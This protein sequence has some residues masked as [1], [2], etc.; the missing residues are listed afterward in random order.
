M[1]RVN[2]Q[3]H[4]GLAALAFLAATAAGCDQE[5]AVKAGRAAEPAVSRVEVVTP[6]RVTMRRT[7]EQ[8]GQ[9][10]AFEV[11]PLYA[12]VSGYVEKWNVDI[13]TKVTKGQVLAVLSVPEL[14][15]EA[16]QKE[17]MIEAAGAVLFQAKASEDVAQANLFRRTRPS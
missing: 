15:A 10:D 13:G 5:S 7:T 11:T 12:K 14:D 2:V 4:V 17:A 9:I 8:P 3:K 1:N 6:E 16:E